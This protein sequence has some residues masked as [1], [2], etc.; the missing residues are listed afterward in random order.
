MGSLRP[1]FS[2]IGL[3]PIDPPIDCV[4]ANH[5]ILHE[6]SVVNQVASLRNTQSLNHTESKPYQIFVSPQST[7]VNA[8]VTSNASFSEATSYKAK[9]IISNALSVLNVN[10]LKCLDMLQKFHSI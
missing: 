2:R 9:S 5:A 1:F 8:C 7:L 10:E 3:P 6:A 4:D